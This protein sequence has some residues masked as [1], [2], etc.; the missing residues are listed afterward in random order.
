MLIHYYQFLHNHDDDLSLREIYNIPTRGIG[1]ITIS[2]IE[3]A[4]SKENITLFHAMKKSD[5]KEVQEFISLMES[6]INDFNIL[7]PKAFIQVL[8]EKIKYQ[9]Y[10]VKL[11]SSKTKINRLNEFIYMMEEIETN[12]DYHKSTMEFLNKITLDN[13]SETGVDNE[14]NYVR[15]MTIHQAKG[16]EFKVV[17]VVGLSDGI[18]PNYKADIKTIEEERRIFYVAITRARERLYLLSAKRRFINGKNLYFKSST[19]L[20][21]IEPDLL[22]LDILI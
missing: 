4:A 16:L 19:F 5:S 11:D 15:L 12:D 18:L 7:H 22:L 6:L 17:I 8:L 14:N 20:E 9:E 21:N 13:K 3:L 2:G 10:V 1:P